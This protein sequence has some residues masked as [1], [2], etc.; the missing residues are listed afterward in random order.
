[1]EA[2]CVKG[3][4][5]IYIPRPTLTPLDQKEKMIPMYHPPVLMRK[6]RYGQH[7]ELVHRD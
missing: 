2:E 5:F 7:D 1:M 6:V 3:H 4:F